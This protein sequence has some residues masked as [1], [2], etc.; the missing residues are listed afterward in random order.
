M[1]DDWIK[2]RTNILTDPDIL[3]LAR[4]MGGQRRAEDVLGYVVKFWFW[5]QEHTHDGH[6]RGVT[7]ED[8]DAALS[9]PHLCSML[10]KI[11]WLESDPDGLGIKIP[12]F[13]R[14]L[15]DGAKSRALANQRKKRQREAKT[16]DSGGVPKMSRSERDKS[17]TREEKRREEKRREEL[18]EEKKDTSVRRSAKPTDPSPFDRWWEIVSNK[19]AKAAA[20]RAYI[21]AVKR[22]RTEKPDVEPHSFLAERR[23]AY[24]ATAKARG[25]FNPHPAT[26][27]SQGRY[28]DDQA[29]WDEPETQTREIEF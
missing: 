18:R 9:V 5:A 16:A 4:N 10:E 6:A 25:Q 1:A 17:V 26:W 7:Y 28:L 15:S 27:L 19:I 23:T 20:K 2:L 3:S 8:I 12:K 29:L 21:Q 11:G 22:I 13:D 14:Y 24:E